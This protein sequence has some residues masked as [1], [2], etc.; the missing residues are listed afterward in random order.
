MIERLDFDAWADGLPPRAPLAPRAEAV[1]S[2]AGEHGA[3]GPEHRRFPLDRLPRPFPL[4]EAELVAVLSACTDPETVGLPLL[5]VVDVETET[6]AYFERE[7]GEVKWYSFA[8]L[9]RWPTECQTDAELDYVLSKRP[10]PPSTDTET[11]PP[12]EETE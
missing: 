11:D 5:A 7:A 3:P 12:T 1:L 4:T 9:P 2:A 10:A 6:P 8:V